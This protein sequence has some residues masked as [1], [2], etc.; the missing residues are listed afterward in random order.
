MIADLLTTL[1]RVNYLVRNGFQVPDF[2]VKRISGHL[3]AQTDFE[4]GQ[5]IIMDRL[6]DEIDYLERLENGR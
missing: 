4:R 2:L 1:D 6:Q 3:E 5:Y